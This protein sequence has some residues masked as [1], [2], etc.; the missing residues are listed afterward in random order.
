MN[1]E[2]LLKKMHQNAILAMNQAYCKYSKLAVGACLYTSKKQFYTGCNVENA[3]FSVTQCAEQNAIGNMVVSGDN[4]IISLLIVSNREQACL[5][6]GV[7][8]QALGEF[9]EPTLTVY[10]ANLDKILESYTL[11]E[12][13]PHA[14]NSDLVNTTSLI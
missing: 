1:E 2:L 12:L 4:K 14:F 3:S 11:A 9:A 8:R 5:P 13:L 7:C 10:I 6:C